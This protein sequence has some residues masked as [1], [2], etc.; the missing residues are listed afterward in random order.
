MFKSA[1]LILYSNLN[2]TELWM[3]RISKRLSRLRSENGNQLPFGRPRKKAQATR[4]TQRPASNVE[5]NYA[6][7]TSKFPL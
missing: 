6:H 5:V 1:N 4:E 3:K 7:T 2:S